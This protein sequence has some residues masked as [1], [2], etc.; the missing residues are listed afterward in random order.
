MHRLARIFAL[1]SLLMLTSGGL[2]AAHLAWEHGGRPAESGENSGC[3]HCCGQHDGTPSSEDERDDGGEHECTTCV[4]LASLV[5]SDGN[6]LVVSL[7]GDA[8]VVVETPRERVEA[9]ECDRRQ[10]A[11]GPPRN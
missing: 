5:V 2:R 4:L 1:L 3:G 9:R 10:T 6:A 7:V 8:W 11:R